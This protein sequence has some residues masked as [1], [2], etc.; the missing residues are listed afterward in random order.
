MRRSSRSRRHLA[1]RSGISVTHV[2]GENLC[3]T[4]HGR[5]RPLGLGGRD[6]D[7][8]DRLRA[9][10]G[11]E[12]WEEFGDGAAYYAVEPDRVLA[13]DMSVHMMHAE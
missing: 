7:Y 1:A 4:V 12:W 10:Y 9:H 5:A 3:L 8:A 11:I 2:E 6:A 13:A